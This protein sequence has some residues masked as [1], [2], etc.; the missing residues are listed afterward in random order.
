MAHAF[1]QQRWPRQYVVQLEC[2][3]AAD[4]QLSALSLAADHAEVGPVHFVSLN[5][6]TDFPGAE[7]SKTGAMA[8]G[9]GVA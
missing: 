5:T 3:L 6:E 2:H 4:L 9:G 8:D 1:F 7:E